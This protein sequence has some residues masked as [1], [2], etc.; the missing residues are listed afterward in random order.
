MSPVLLVA[1]ILFAL[2][3]LFFAIYSFF[4]IYILLDFTLNK[5]SALVLICVFIGVSVVLLFTIFMYLS[6]VNWGAPAFPFLQQFT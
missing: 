2:V 4:M 6:L 1:T 3:I 5:A